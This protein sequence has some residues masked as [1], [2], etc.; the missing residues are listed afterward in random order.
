MNTSN[1]FTKA[2]G[3]FVGLFNKCNGT[4]YSVKAAL[5]Q[6]QLVELFNSVRCQ[7]QYVNAVITPFNPGSTRHKS[8][9]KLDHG[10]LATTIYEFIKDNPGHSRREIAENL[11]MRLQTVCGQVNVLVREGFIHVA[12]T[13]KDIETKREVETLAVGC[14]GPR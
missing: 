1:E 4:Q 6:I 5:Q 3:I 2:F 8:H 7:S 10:R 14:Y 13:K 11:N 12:G 9:N